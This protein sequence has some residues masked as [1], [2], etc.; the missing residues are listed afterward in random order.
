MIAFSLSTLKNRV[1]V[2]GSPDFGRTSVKGMGHRPWK[3]IKFLSRRP[4]SVVGVYMDASK[5]I[6]YIKYNY[7]N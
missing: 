7:F 6:Y 5:E 2:L 1:P 4:V 3:T